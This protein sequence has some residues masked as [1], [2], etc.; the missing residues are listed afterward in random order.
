MSSTAILKNYP[1]TNPSRWKKHFSRADAIWAGIYVLLMSWTGAFFMADTVDYV[2]AA[3]VRDQ[4]INYVFWDFRHLFWRPLGWVA[5]H[6]S[7]AFVHYEGM[8]DAR[9][10]VTRF[11]IALNLLAGL[12][13]VLLLRRILLRFCGRSWAV[14]W[15]LAAFMFAQGFMNFVHSGSSYAFGLGWL[16]VG[17]YFLAAEASELTHA[18]ILAGALALALAVCFWFP[19]FFAVLGALST[20]LFLSRQ[21][22]RAVFKAAALCLFFGVAFYGSVILG[23]HLH[24]VAEIRSWIATGASDVA[25]VRGP[26]R[27]IFGLAR[28][29]VNMGQDGV[30]YKRFLLHDPYNPVS[31]SQLLRLSIFKLAIFYLLMFAIIWDLW[32]KRKPVLVFF[33][34]GVLPVIAFGLYWYGGDVERYLPLY[35]FYFVGLASALEASRT[36]ATRVIAVVF[37]I[38]VVISN[39]SA[40]SALSL[41]RQERRAEDRLQALLPVYKPHSRVVLV[42]IH[43]E[44]ENFSRSFPLLPIVN[45]S[46]FAFYPALNPGTPQNLHWKQDFSKIADRAWNEGGDVWLSRRFF[47]LHPRADSAWVE[48]DDV[49]VKWPQVYQFFSQLDQGMSVGGEDGFVLLL[50]DQK[51]RDL[52]D[53]VAADNARR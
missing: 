9:A 12:V 50:P 47:D 37:L 21:N 30:L 22:W 52:L 11:F 42:D 48:G 35:P 53:G 1:T 39:L 45:R 25:G 18:R 15:S 23:L 17:V 10:F 32:R 29:F 51:D 38:V 20:P 43:D 16:V 40:M 14:N 3:V 2:Q 19:Y 31:L 4:G 41:H 5:F 26:K 34:L 49:H 13:A 8:A 6:Y 7:K 46:D 27:T 44:L 33:A 36:V 28:S 24:N